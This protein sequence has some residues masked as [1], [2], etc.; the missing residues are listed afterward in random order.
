M[1]LR[2]CVRALA[3]ALALLTAFAPLAVADYAAYVS[4]PYAVGYTDSALT[5]PIG[6]LAGGTYVTLRAHS[7][8]VAKI[9]YNG[10]DAF[11]PLSTLTV[12]TQ[13]A[14][15]VVAA[16]NTYFFQRPSTSSAWK[17][18][19]QGTSV[20]LLAVSGACAM[21][22]WNGYIGY[23]HAQHL[24]TEASGSS[25]QSA[26]V[27]VANVDTRIYQRPSTSSASMALSRGTKVT[28]RAVNG[29]CAMV[30]LNGVTGYV[31][32]SHFVS[33][34]D[35]VPT[36]TQAVVTSVNT[37][38]YQYPTTSSA[39]IP[40]QMGTAL[41]L[42]DV[43][44]S[45]AT[46]QLNGVTGY[47]L[48]SHLRAADEQPQEMTVNQDT[49]FFSRPS[50]SSAHIPLAQGTQVT[51]LAVNGACAMVE[52]N[53]VAGYVDVN[54]LSA[55]GTQEP[56]QDS[57]ASQVVV[58]RFSATVTADS[59]NVYA[60]ASTS[61]TLMGVL[62][63]GAV[64]TVVAYNDDWAQLEN[65]STIG[66]AP[67]AG[68]VRGVVSVTPDPAPQV[69][70]EQLVA[71][72]KYSNEE[73]IYLFLTQEMNLNCAAAC[74]ILA[75]IRAE[76]SFRP[77]A[78]N[79]SGGS[80]G[81]CQWT[82][83]RKTRLQNYCKDAG[84]DYTTLTG[85]LYYLEYELEN[86]YTKTLTYIRGVENSAQGAYDAGYYWCYNFEVPANRES[87]SRSRGETARD[88]YWPKYA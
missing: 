23:V 28:L 82:G 63:K 65:G 69:T 50:V 22:E 72:G 51:L 17:G 68:L 87:R 81:I 59:L 7:G 71:S 54:C 40:L 5:Q 13:A 45:C 39:S 12:S 2:K 16:T 70:F 53:G 84:L 61:A 35:Y 62:G 4:V 74:G 78:Y 52:F 38:F 30:E 10:V 60:S 26:E 6:A 3:L 25:G 36:P 32:A 43:D 42:L 49:Y 46:V 27:I 9:T 58:E 11:M 20:S 34:A 24:S 73:L 48:T 80:Y 79:S 8:D 47:V 55:Q 83:S 64:V 29:D 37:F 41:A 44:G 75:N 1:S 66:Y 14:Q 85:Q 67:R 33:E 57:S 18:L 19:P 21:V 76:S 86:H 15:Q 31:F 56:E 88:T 77:T